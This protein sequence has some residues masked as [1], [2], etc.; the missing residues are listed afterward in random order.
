MTFH[1]HTLGNGLQIV[2]ETSPKALS[3][4]IGF[5]VRTGARD[6]EP[7]VAGV[8]HFLEHM[9]FKGTERRTYLDVN[10]DF[11][12]IG[13]Q[14]N[15][16]TSEENTVF[17]ATVLPEY[18]P[19]AIDI[20]ADI[21]RPSLRN[22]DFDKEKNVIIEEIN[23]Y[24][25]QPMSSAYE[26]GRRIHFND[27]P[28]GNSVLGTAQSVG[29]LSREQMHDYFARRYVAANVTVAVA[30]NVDWSKL[31]GMVEEHC[32]RW[33]SGPV[34]RHHVREA[35]GSRQFQLV[36][37]ESVTQEHVLLFSSGPPAHSPLRYAAQVLS[38]VIGDDSG[39]RLYWALVDPGLVESADTGFSEY[40]GAGCF[41]TSFICEPEGTAK[42]LEIVRELLRDVQKNGI[43]EE[44]LQVAKSKVTSREVRH[45]ER[46]RGRMF[47]V[48]MNWTYL[49]QYRSVDDELQA[50]DAVTLEQVR[51]VL[52]R[53]PLD[54]TTTL[55]LGPLAKLDGHKKNGK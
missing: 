37:K 5:F 43:T 46:P 14:Y 29:E 33:N 17:Y 49:K 44:E 16:Y 34:E 7:A 54:Q 45:N 36:T 25:D 1:H 42:N 22:D 11:D 50:F 55:A 35:A 52:D 24:L 6:E 51:E 12:R 18:L 15:A 41:I 53:Y 31:V 47:A 4:A 2:G 27:H 48:G 30:G 32:G 9:V 21:L 20:L 38:V 10:K 19:D 39:S 26:Q 28:L 23:M 8:S 13:A 40:E 3:A